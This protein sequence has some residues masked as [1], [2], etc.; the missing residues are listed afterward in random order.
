[1]KTTNKERNMKNFIGTFIICLIVCYLFLFFGGVLIFENIWALIIFTAFIIAILITTFISQ[2]TKIEE[3][4][5][6]VKALE[7]PE[8]QK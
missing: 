1:M 4:E 3:L 5:K 6:R 7:S 8:D 2:E